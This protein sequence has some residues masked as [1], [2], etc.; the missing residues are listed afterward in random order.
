MMSIGLFPLVSM[1]AWLPFLPSS[2]WA[3]FG[4]TRSDAVAPPRTALDRLG[5][6]TAGVLIVYVFLLLA[7]RAH[8]LPTI[9]PSQVERMGQ[10]LRIQQTWNMFAP[11]PPRASTIYEIRRVLEDG[12]VTYEPAAPGFRWTTYLRAASDIRQPD[13]PLS[14]SMRRFALLRCG[15]PAP[16]QA[17]PTTGLEVLAHR[18]ETTPEGAGDAW[19]TT[20]MAVTCGDR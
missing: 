18:R 1:V 17:A 2:A 19:T 20:R 16:G 14:R 10:V 4:A 3:W 12:T 5:S 9:I 13:H 8:L 15:D 11:D 6:T 7:Q